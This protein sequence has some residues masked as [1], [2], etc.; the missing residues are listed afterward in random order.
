LEEHEKLPSFGWSAKKKEKETMKNIICAATLAASTLILAP[1]ANATP[2]E[3][4]VVQQTAAAGYHYTNIPAMLNNAHK[5][6]D[7]LAAGQPR[8]QILG[9]IAKQV[10]D[11]AEADTF[12]N[13][14]VANLCP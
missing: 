6:C 2:E 10:G 13:V 12:V 7:R 4:A 11:P 1:I 8:E 14:S 5:V 3:D 9:D